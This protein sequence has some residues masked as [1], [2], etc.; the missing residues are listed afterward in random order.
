MNAYTLVDGNVRKKLDETLKTWREPVPGSMQT[1][2]VFRLEI[3]QKI[4]DALSKARQAAQ[5]A[6]AQQMPP[7]GSRMPIIQGQPYRSTPTPP[8]A[9][10]Y[11]RPSSASY[12]QP[13][14]RN[15]FNNYPNV[16]GSGY[17]QAQASSKT[18]CIFPI[19]TRRRS[20]S[21]L[22]LRTLLNP[23]LRIRN[24]R[25]TPRLRRPLILMFSIT[26]LMT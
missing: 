2:P 3:T 17:P 6:R 4:V 8:N 18:Y 23:L 26:T 19:L 11:G 7:M 9:G 5:Q 12:N 24:F 21:S 10:N 20:L 25:T 1:A 22:H 16:T 13:P 15:G 14:G